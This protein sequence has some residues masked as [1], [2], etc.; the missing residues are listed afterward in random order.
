[1]EEV[2]N[3]VT[4]YNDFLKEYNQA[5]ATGE[6]VGEMICIMAQYFCNLN[7]EYSTAKSAF[8]KIAAAI[9]G[10]SDESTGKPIS[11][12]KADVLAQAT[13]EASRLTQA[14][15]DMQNIEQFINAL[16]SLQRGILNEYSYTGNM[17]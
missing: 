6:R 4:V 10:T 17:G 12:S 1:M 3:Y 8:D 11:S 15:V 9:A 13:N 7:Q 2:K 5:Q 16:K 14:K